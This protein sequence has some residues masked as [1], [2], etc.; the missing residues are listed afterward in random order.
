MSKEISV[1]DKLKQWRKINTFPQSQAKAFFK[2]EGLPVTLDSLQ[3][4]ES[5]YRTPR[6]LAAVALL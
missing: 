6:G 2:R 3:N 4:W 5:G 1:Q